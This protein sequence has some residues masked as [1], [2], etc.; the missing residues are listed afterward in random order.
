MDCCIKEKGEV[1]RMG[2]YG[3]QCRCK[4]ASERP[5]KKASEHTESEVTQR[6]QQDIYRRD[7]R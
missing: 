4:T 6:A 1:I 2:F 7:D 3:G 5:V